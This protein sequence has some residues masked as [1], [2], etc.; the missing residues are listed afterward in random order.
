MYEIVILGSS[1]FVGNN[2]VNSLKKKYTLS[3][4]DINSSVKLFCNNVKFKKKNI[5]KL[6][7][8]D[9]P[10]KNF[11]VI[12]V[13]AILGSKNYEDNYKNNVLTVKKLLKIL[14]KKKTFKGLIHFSSISAQRRISHYGNTK[15]LSEKIVRN[16]KLPHIILQSEMIVG[17]GARSIEKL[18]K[19]SKLFPL[20]LPLP[21]GGNVI[22]YPIKIN[23]V[24]EIV[25]DIIK[26]KSFDNKT[27]SLVSKKVLF[28][29]FLKKLIKNK[30][31]ITIP[32]KFLLLIAKFMEKFFNNPI[33]TY[34]NAYGIVSDTELKY[35]KY[36]IKKK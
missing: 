14:K 19:V 29:T 1:G 5:L 26:N 16:S 25:K 11:I 15:Y 33:F 34:D 22:R 4:F 21:N 35:P 32:V 30:I 7:E 8:S 24:N 13:A 12:N 6:E 36:I 3:L 17:K 2:L 20:F 31:F 27:Y 28:V 18:K 23:K 10:K 9:F